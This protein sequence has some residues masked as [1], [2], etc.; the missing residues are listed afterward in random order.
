MKEA[1]CINFA[2][3]WWL[4]KAPEHRCK[5]VTIRSSTSTA[6]NLF[7]HFIYVISSQQ[8]VQGLEQS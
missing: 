7:F 2:S 1:M 3:V 5:W 6:Q 4:C 8:I